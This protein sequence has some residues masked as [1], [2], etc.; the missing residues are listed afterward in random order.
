MKH[1][2]IFIDDYIEKIFKGEKT[3]EARFSQDKIAPY[4]LVKKGDEVYL[5]QSSKNIIGRFIVDNVLYYQGL[6]GETIGKLR[7]EYNNEICANDAFWQSKAN[8]KYGT[9]IFIS[10]P[11]RFL[12]P[13]RHT[14]HDRRAWLVLEND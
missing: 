1:L 12:T 4:C 11:E 7:K 5:K 2:A 6:T 9:L 3:I 10:Q 13:I 8:A 14:K